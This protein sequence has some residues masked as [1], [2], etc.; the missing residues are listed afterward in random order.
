[1]RLLPLVL[2][3][4]AAA[5]HAQSSTQNGP[6]AYPAAFYAPS[7]PHNALDMIR[8][9]PGF[10]LQE[11][12]SRRGYAGS[13]GNVLI[14]GRRPLGKNQTLE[15]ALQLIPASQVVRIEILSGPDVA[16]DPSGFS[17]LANVVRVASAGQGIW[18]AG[19]EIGN[20]ARPAPDGF[21]NWSGRFHDTT[22]DVGGETYSLQRDQPGDYR[23]VDGH[24]AP[25]ST[26]HEESPR[27]YYEYAVN[28]SAARPLLGGNLS[29]SGKLKYSRYHEDTVLA[30]HPVTGPDATQTTPYT[31]TTEN[32]ELGGQYDR[33]LGPW[34]MSLIGLFTRTHV[35]SGV[36]STQEP[37][38]DRFEQHL[39]H[40]SAEN[41]LRGSLAR[42]LG[43]HRLEFG[44][45]RAGN[46]LDAALDLT[47][48]TG[49]VTYPIDLP[50]S[51]S[52][53]IERRDDLYA[54][55]L[56]QVAPHLS[57]ELRLGYERPVLVF[58]GD[59]DKRVAYGFVKPSV[60]VTRTFGRDQL[61][62][63][64]YRDIGQI[65]FDDFVSAASLKD[66]VINGGNPDLRP[67]T[68][69]RGE[70]GS[71]F[72]FGARTTLGFK[73]YHAVLSDTADLVP[74][75]KDGQAYD[76]PGNI[77]RGEITG[78]S[79]SLHLPL[80]R[81]IPGG[82][83]QADI[84]RQSTRVTDPLT[85]RTRIISNLATST[86]SFAFRQDL[87]ARHLAWG[88]DY[89]DASALSKFRFDE[90]DTTRE[91]PQLDLY[92]ERNNV[93]PYSLKATLHSDAGRPQTRDRVFYDPDR[94]GAVVRRESQAHRPGLWLNI[95][96]SRLF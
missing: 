55:D 48:T 7:Q 79:L 6:A 67:Q 53:I 27:S 84:M 85:R 74:V 23:D 41:I 26:G 52:D 36:L 30:T 31:E 4:A 45:E 59:T 47:F 9:T 63:R 1:M 18:G 64:L 58:T 25:V 43:A 12:D 86:E 62:F 14:D 5:A 56:W 15:D 61:T 3:L 51:N 87:P 73:L 11:G 76:A 19:A 33:D 71:D 80:D 21:I 88:I 28:G 16:G 68:Q 50:D 82:V 46:S 37:G 57:A 60:T 32:A 22:Y 13:L 94:N 77:G 95:N 35:F 10:T 92:V 44:Y 8:Q 72:H 29:L 91:S 34:K 54:A 24:G 66:A 39:D 42:T 81:L 65:D 89:S 69:W 20:R 38:G 78:A 75:E 83:L 17:I 90:T 40:R 2:V 93:G 70:L 49:G 96:L